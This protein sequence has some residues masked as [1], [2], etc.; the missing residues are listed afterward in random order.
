MYSPILISIFISFVP[1]PCVFYLSLAT[2][3]DVQR[4]DGDDLTKLRLPFA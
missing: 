3:A 2:E 1:E 4:E